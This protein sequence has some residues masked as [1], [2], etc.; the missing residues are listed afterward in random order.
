MDLTV[1]KNNVE[2]IMNGYGG[3]V[4][5]IDIKNSRILVVN[6]LHYNNKK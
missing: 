3:N 6:S 1:L 4:I 5:L 2:F